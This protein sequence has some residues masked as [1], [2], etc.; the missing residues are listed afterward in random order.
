MLGIPRAITLDLDDT[1]WPIA[2]AIDRAEAALD[3]WLH[4]HAPRAAGRWPLAARRRLRDRV[5]RE[6]PELAHDFS[7]QRKITLEHMLRDSGEDVGLVGS[8]FEA[9]FAARCQVEHYPD[10]LAALERLA[11]HVPLA[12]ISNGNAC[13]LRV[14]LSDRFAFQLSARDHGLGKPAASIFHAACARLQLA[15]HDVLHVGD[16]PELDVVGAI[17]AGLRAVWLDRQA[18]AWDHPHLAPERVFADLTALADWLDACVKADA[19][20]V[21][22]MT[23]HHLFRSFA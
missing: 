21:R 8:A 10:T 20:A 7:A 16:D 1:L 4:T 15:P 2:P 14:G 22:S 17:N 3:V 23:R 11:A 18:R 9:Y 19:A 13:L 12:A 6:R 5:E